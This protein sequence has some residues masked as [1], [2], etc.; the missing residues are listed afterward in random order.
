MRL[1]EL[2][3]FV[4]L[5]VA[6]HSGHGQDIVKSEKLV[7]PVS[8]Q[9]TESTATTVARQNA[10]MLL[11]DNIKLIIG[12]GETRNYYVRVREVHNLLCAGSDPIICPL[13]VFFVHK[14]LKLLE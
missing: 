2:T 10:D 9:P 12:Q 6:G 8:P 4:G 1:I 5:L 13:F 11:P 3:L 14:K 7:E